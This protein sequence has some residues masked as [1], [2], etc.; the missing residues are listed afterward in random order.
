MKSM[1]CF[2]SRSNN[3]GTR[4]R[5]LSAVCLLLVS[6]L[7][8]GCA[9]GAKGGAGNGSIRIGVG[10]YQTDD[11]FINNLRAEL[12]NRAKEYEQETGAKITL[13]I[14]SAKGNQRTQNSQVDRFLSLDC[15]VL[16]I[17]PVDRMAVST[18]IDKA[19]S[20][21]VPVVFFNRQPVEEDMNR[22]SE[23]YYVGVDARETAVLQGQIVADHYRAD[24]AAFDRNGDGIVSY[25]LLEG[26]SSHQDSL[27]RTEWSIQTL[28]DAGVPIERLTGGIANWERPQ[29][30]ALMEQWLEQYP[31]QIE[32][33]ISNNDDMALGALDAM[34]RLGAAGIEVV[35][36]DAT[37]PGLE[38]VRSGRMMG[39]VSADREEYARAIFELAVAKARNEEIP[40]DLT[41]TDGNYCWCPQSVINREDFG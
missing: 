23:L 38:A 36:I 25:V 27:I 17:N 18:M 29:A 2:F 39:T 5:L 16:C 22:W 1:K 11:T 12:E 33:V 19:I 34:D 15:D 7:L 31:G 26:E 6:A 8:G 14:Q 41:L 30:S 10:L 24:P 28:K 13:D 4:T 3:R 35:G 37:E 40:S 20:A 21:K 32:L 9:G